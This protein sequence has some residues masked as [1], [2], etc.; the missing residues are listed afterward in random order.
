MQRW[1][2]YV[3]AFL[4]GGGCFLKA[5]EFGIC[6]SLLYDTMLS[7]VRGGSSLTGPRVL[8]CSLGV[9]LWGRQWGSQQVAHQDKV[10]LLLFRIAFPL[11]NHKM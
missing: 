6:R 10:K 2:S 11:K 5:E 7:S 3:E 1:L 4:S 9:G 8:D